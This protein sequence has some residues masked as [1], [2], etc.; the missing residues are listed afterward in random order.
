[1]NTMLTRFIIANRSESMILAKYKMHINN[2]KK[3]KGISHFNAVDKYF[4]KDNSTKS[5]SLSASSMLIG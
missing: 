3:A 5:T 2:S 1:M 4:F